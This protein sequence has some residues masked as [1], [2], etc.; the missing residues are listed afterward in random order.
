MQYFPIT[1]IRIVFSIIVVIFF[2]SCAQ[3]SAKEKPKLVVMITLDQFRAGYLER[4]D[5]VFT[6]GFRRLR[7]Q[8]WR[9]DTALVDHAPTLSW[10]GHT[11][12]YT[13]AHPR[14]H[15]VVTNDI[16]TEDGYRKLIFV[17]EEEHILGYPD[18]LSFSP[19][20]TKVKGLGDWM[21][22]VDPDCRSVS[23]NI[24][25]TALCYGGKPVLD[26]S[27]NHVYWIE[28]SAGQFVTSTYY[29]DDYPD[30]LE[31]FNDE[32]LP[33]YKEKLEWE[34]S[35]P[36]AFRHL[37]RPDQAPCEFDGIHTTFPHHIGDFYQE[38]HQQTV[39][40][41]FSRFSPY[42]N[43]ALFA[44]AKE[45]IQVL[46]LG[47][48]N[49][50]D[51]LAISVGLTDRIGHDFGPRSLEQLDVI[52]RLDRELGGFFD[53]LDATLGKNNC[54]IALTGD[55]G[56]PNIVEYEIEQGRPAKRVAQEELKNLL[57]EI[58]NFID[59]YS[60]PE[61]AL[62]S[63]IARELEKSDFIARAMTPDDLAGNGPADHI[64]KS[65][66]NTFI[67]GL[68]TTFPLWTDEILRG[69]VSPKHPGNY[70]LIVEFVENAQLYTARSA[71]ASSYWYD[72]EVPIIFMGKD[73][74]SVV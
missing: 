41:Y 5:S 48:R 13:G 26:K 63:R 12:I 29:R 64:L 20:I 19:R 74:K 36:E 50:T 8:G 42:A 39:N 34:N 33:E 23:L 73:R 51:F 11:T 67:P 6:G 55:H 15:G 22:S 54:I 49:A 10:P 44:L 9:Y 27:Q 43:E 28:P 59:N 45:C 40:A 52:V 66:R 7:D 69:N 17:D 1:F 24:T 31:K 62:P 32:I 2:H 56:G 37:A 46:E 38:I 60:G 71:H 72:Q 35:V 4:Y 30:W 61:E 68:K 3:D 65:Y 70:G 58:E 16:I 14:T 18:A 57:S 47:G 53:F 21:K 25:T